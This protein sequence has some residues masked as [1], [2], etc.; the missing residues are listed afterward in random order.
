MSRTAQFIKSKVTLGAVVVLA[1]VGVFA[2][3][4][5]SQGS[6]PSSNQSTPTNNTTQSTDSLSY[7]GE[8]GKTAL[9]L[10]KQKAQVETKDS[11]FGE[12]VTAINGND[13]DGQKYWLFY[14]NGK[15]AS[16]GA[17][18]YKTQDGE[19]IEWRLE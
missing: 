9:E 14:V 10:L 7:Q 11:S 4:T 8:N 13:G 12:Y 1:A 17:G 5:N 16:E 19:T 15:Q 6:N 2:W 3:Q 18:T